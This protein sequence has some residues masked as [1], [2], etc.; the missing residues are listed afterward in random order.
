[1]TF[2][3]LIYQKVSDRL[4][5]CPRRGN[6]GELHGRHVLTQK[7]VRWIRVNC[8]PGSGN[9][10]RG[11]T[12]HLGGERRRHTEPSMNA[13]AEELGVCRKQIRRILDRENWG[14]VA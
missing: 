5:Y 4:P 1:M 8:R 9:G 3:E 7:Q 2:L 6:K 12:T 10:Q 13:I 11:G 14:H